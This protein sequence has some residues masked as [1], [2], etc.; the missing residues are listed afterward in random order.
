MLG[1]ITYGFDDASY[2][3]VKKWESIYRNDEIFGICRQLGIVDEYFQ[4]LYG[5]AF[6][7]IDNYEILRYVLQN[8]RKRPLDFQMLDG[9]GGMKWCFKRFF[10]ID[11]DELQTDMRVL[12]ECP[13]TAQSNTR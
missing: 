10:N 7:E 6:Q 4:K 13:A 8:T 2:D 3:K 1:D 5:N 12:K 9:V 11:V